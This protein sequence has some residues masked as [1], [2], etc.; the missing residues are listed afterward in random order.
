ME[1]PEEALVPP[2]HP[3]TPNNAAEEP[4]GI[5]PKGFQ[6][7]GKISSMI[8]ERGISDTQLARIGM[9]SA[10]LVF[11][12]PRSAE[13]VGSA[14]LPLSG[15]ALGA[16]YAEYVNRMHPSPDATPHAA[17]HIVIGERV[18]PPNSEF[19]ADVQVNVARVVDLG[20]GA[21]GW[22]LNASEPL[23][24]NSPE[25]D[26]AREVK[27]GLTQLLSEAEVVE[28]DIWADIAVQQ[29]RTASSMRFTGEA[30][31]FER[32][33]TLAISLPYTPMTL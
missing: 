19:D 26:N 6:H 17:S 7:F 3:A 4:G 23:A 2:D 13:S 24:E 27:E 29:R 30:A 10:K 11:D 20:R 21:P 15:D 5:F 32:N 28:P 16:S 12:Q 18:T 25:E 14:P 22:H 9:P 31:T 8:P 1:Y 33:L